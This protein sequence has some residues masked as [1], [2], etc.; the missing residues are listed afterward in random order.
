MT[1]CYM[2]VTAISML[3]LAAALA[4]RRAAIGVRDEFISIASHELKTP[5]T[6]L[7]LRLTVGD[8]D[9]R[10]A[11]RRATRRPRRSWRARWPPPA[12][13]PT[14]SSAWSTICSTSRG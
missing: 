5:L 8:P 2:A 12:R 6:A 3:T 9:A 4:E 10:R 11:R 7:K 13:R 1:D 14:G